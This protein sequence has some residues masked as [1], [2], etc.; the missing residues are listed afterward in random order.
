ME[1]G[2]KKRKKGQEGV[3]RICTECG[4]PVKGLASASYSGM[5]I[6]AM[7]PT[8]RTLTANESEELMKYFESCVMH[9]IEAECGVYE[10][11]ISYR[12]RR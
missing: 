6:N 7:W 3:L 11:V 10:K 1:Q 9:S 4:E 5:Q 8:E 12:R 2:G